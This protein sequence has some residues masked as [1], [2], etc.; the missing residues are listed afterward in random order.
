MGAELVFPPAGGIK[1][2]RLVASILTGRDEQLPII[3]CDDDQPGR[4]AMRDF[5]A[6]LYAT[7]PDRL[8]SLKDIVFDGA[9][10]EDLFPA[11]FLA[12]LIDRARNLPRVD[13]DITEV[14]DPC[15]PFVHQVEVWAAANGIKLPRHWKIDLA[16]EAKRR[17]L[18]R[19]IAAFN[20]DTIERWRKLFGAFLERGI[21]SPAKPAVKKSAPRVGRE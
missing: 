17:A 11:E 6:T 20:E 10:V 16:L 13:Q 4:T 7:A 2:A 1:T 18:Q 8:L 12:G 15:K 19:G 3:L 21:S 9:E 5:A 14:I